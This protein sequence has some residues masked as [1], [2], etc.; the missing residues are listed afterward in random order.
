VATQGHRAYG[1]RRRRSAGG[2]A[3]ERLS[4]VTR[5]MPP[6][7]SQ[8][9]SVGASVSVSASPEVT[10]NQGDLTGTRET[11][12]TIRETKHLLRGR[13]HASGTVAVALVMRTSWVRFPPRALDSRVKVLLTALRRSHLSSV[14]WAFRVRVPNLTHE[15]DTPV[16]PRRCLRVVGATL[17]FAYTWIEVLEIRGVSSDQIGSADD[18]RTRDLRTYYGSPPRCC[19]EI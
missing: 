18:G 19:L 6:R 8:R 12:G 10:R 15:S 3:A 17:M 4:T 5:P 1:V 14:R 11:T 16:S 9:S 13:S 7:V 2:A